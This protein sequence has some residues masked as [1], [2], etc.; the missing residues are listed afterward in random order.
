MPETG[1]NWGSW[2]AVPE[3]DA[4]D[5]T[6]ETQ[7]DASGARSDPISNDGKAATEIS[8]KMVEDNTGAIDGPVTITILGD[9]DGTL[10]EEPDVGNAVS[11][12]VTPVQND[13][14]VT[15]FRIL[16]SDYSDVR[17]HVQNECG[18]ELVTTLKFRQATIPVAT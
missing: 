14:V 15:R 8:V 12:D 17:I 13:T 18:Q 9:T 10:Y 4:S 3:E 11:W 5:W 6:D 16:G 1:Y 2:A 7:A